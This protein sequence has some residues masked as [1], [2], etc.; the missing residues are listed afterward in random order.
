MEAASH[1]LLARQLEKIA[2]FNRQ[3]NKTTELMNAIYQKNIHKVSQYDYFPYEISTP[4]SDRSPKSDFGRYKTNSSRLSESKLSKSNSN[5]NLNNVTSISARSN[6]SR[7]S[8]P[9]S[10]TPHKTEI[11]EISSPRTEMSPVH[12]RNGMMMSFSNKDLLSTYRKS[13]MNN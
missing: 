10:R 5:V 7:K 2:E 6:I 13:K 8:A 3:V 9:P 4:K 11:P 1:Q 12:D